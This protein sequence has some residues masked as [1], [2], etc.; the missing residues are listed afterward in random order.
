MILTDINN[1][2][3]RIANALEELAGKKT[4][5]PSKEK[6][7]IE[8]VEGEDEEQKKENEKRH[9][10]IAEIMAKNDGKHVW[11]EENLLEAREDYE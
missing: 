1:N 4:F 9:D 6:P 11:E 3:L 2:L 5:V 7:K 8:I 10:D